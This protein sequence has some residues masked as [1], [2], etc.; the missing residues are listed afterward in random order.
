VFF[1]DAAFDAFKD[2]TL[3]AIVKM[4]MPLLRS[5]AEL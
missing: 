1:K 3:V 4:E 5:A 2:L